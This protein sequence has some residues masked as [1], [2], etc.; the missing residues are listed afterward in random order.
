M[1]SLS[2]RAPQRL[3]LPEP[4]LSLRAQGTTS[5]ALPRNL[6]LDVI[7]GGTI[8]LVVLGHAIQSHVNQFDHNVFFRL[9]YSFHMPLFM[10]LSGWVA[11]PERPR[12]L[13]KTSIRLVLPVVSWYFIGYFLH[14]Q[15]HTIALSAFVLEWVKSPDVGLWFLWVLFLCHLW[16]TVAWLISRWL[17]MWSY[18]ICAGLLC[19]VPFSEMGMK[20]VRWDFP[21][22]ALGYVVALHWDICAKYARHAAIVGFLLFSLAFPHW[23]RTSAGYPS[24]P[25]HFAGAQLEIGLPVLLATRLVCA[26][27]GSIIF[28]CLLTVAA[29]E[30]AKSAL[31]WL[32]TI[33]L[34]IYAIHQLLIH[35]A[36]GQG[37][38]AVASSLIITTATS[39]LA[40]WF[41]NKSTL[42][43]LILFGR[44]PTPDVHS[45][46]R[47]GV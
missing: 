30:Q 31:S 35:F 46:L 26:L 33:T 36:F 3:T 43:A 28:S 24:V 6:C 5:R 20:M 41:L 2:S 9:I 34:E 47:H 17:G 1:P 11:R 29:P 45:S 12:K 16:L 7:K 15:Y 42:T 8:L 25:L 39:V 22:V 4:Q 38:A 13:T 23:Q 18:F 44:I 19:A 32:G 14:G 21:F 37:A 27:A 40:V 10:I